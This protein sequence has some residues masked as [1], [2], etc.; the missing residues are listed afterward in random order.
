MSQENVQATVIYLSINFYVT[1][2]LEAMYAH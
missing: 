1:V 2:Y